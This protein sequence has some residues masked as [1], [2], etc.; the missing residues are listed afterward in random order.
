MGVEGEVATAW[1]GWRPFRIAE[2]HRESDV[3]TSFILVPADGGA[4]AP[5]RSG[6]YLTFE[7]DIPGAGK[8]G[9]NY[10]I[11][12]APNGQ[13]YRITVKREPE[14]TASRWLHDEAGVGTEI[15]V[16]VPSGSFALPPE[17][18]R[19]V[20]LLS[21]GVGLTP[22]VA[23]LETIAAEHPALDTYYVHAATHGGVHAM[24]AHVEDLT[25]GRD[26][27]RIDTFYS[28]P[29]AEDV[30]GR[31]YAHTGR[32]DID[33][34][35]AHTPL[36]RADIYVCGPIPFLRTFV[37]GLNEAGVPRDRL[38]YE[39]FGS[40]AELME[41]WPDAPSDVETGGSDLHRARQVDGPEIT[42]DAV[43]A[44][45][46]DTE[47]DAVVASDAG[48]MIVLWNPG[49][50][51]I[52]GFTA[53]EAV[54]RSLDIMIPE[55]LRARHWEG[56]HHTVATGQSRYGAGDLLA[57]PGI[58]KDGTR[59]SLEFT[60]MLIKGDDGRVSGM[61]SNLR[62]VTKRFEE[63]RALKKRIAEIEKQA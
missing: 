42:H 47:A 28:D 57:V 7:F 17:P 6:Q 33:W 4:V 52:F 13:S 26:A 61:V 16:A 23:M 35:R 15:R 34:L 54:G 45:L 31:D 19:P 22:M 12:S 5:H 62:D 41:R 36:D 20:V 38:H 32:I 63:V 50:E 44:A 46:V 9:R 14:G 30:A 49:A 40:S 2:R 3:I 39:F 8:V 11:S 27:I 60:I 24:R 43:G 37:T 29:R 53:E 51:R 1:S 25:R 55:Q 48:G 59:I 10:T 21:G 58:R 56:Y 18:K